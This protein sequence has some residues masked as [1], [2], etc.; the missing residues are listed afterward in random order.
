MPLY[1]TFI[2]YSHAKDKPIAAAL[3]SRWC[4]SSASPGTSAGRCAYFV[5]TPRSPP[6]CSFGPRCLHCKRQRNGFQ[7]VRLL[8]H[9]AEIEGLIH[10]G[11]LKPERRHDRSAVETA[12]AVFIFRQLAPRE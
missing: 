5:M 4:R 10:R 6:R 2:S 12:V 11:L 1:D 8:L 7:C 3:H 9:E